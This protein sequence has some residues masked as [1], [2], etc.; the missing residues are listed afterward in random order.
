MKFHDDSF[1]ESLSVARVLFYMNRLWNITRWVNMDFKEMTEEDIKELVRKIEQM[2][3]TEQ[4]K[5]DH[6]KV[7]KKFFKWL[8][9]NDRRVKW[10]KTWMNRNNNKL[11]DEL[12]NKDDIWKLIKACY[13]V[14]DKAVISVLWESGCRVG[15]LLGMRIKS[16]QFD[17]KG[18]VII[19]H[20]KT[21][22]RRLRLVSSVPHLSNWLEHHPRKDDPEAPLWISIGSKSHAEQVMYHCL[23]ARL[24]KIAKRA[25]I[26][27]KVNPHMF[28]HSRATDLANLLTEA[29]MKKYFGWT[30]D[31][32]MVGIYVHLSG[33][34]VDEA[35]LRIHGKLDEN[36]KLKHEQLKTQ[37]CPICQHENAPEADFC[38][39]CRRP[40]NLRALL[41]TEEKEKELLRL[42]TPEMIEQMIQ[43]RVEEILARYMPQAQT[44]AEP[45]KIKVMV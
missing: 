40:L 3:Y 43:R 34:D 35:I 37:T 44:Q 38:L 8:D 12:L 15:E 31:S 22:S 29:Q 13:N 14:R 28:R 42:I 39:R 17:D 2:N 33:R 27:K 45:L 41:E 10:I 21:G 18:A 26:K 6:K 24:R 7:I 9:G 36:E 30:K 25:G 23:N 1:A 32:K 16:V 4:T 19:V 20:G 5:L 11:P